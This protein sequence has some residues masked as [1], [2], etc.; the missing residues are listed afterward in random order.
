MFDENFEYKIN[1]ADPDDLAILD[2][3]SEAKF[4]CIKQLRIKNPPLHIDSR[5]EK[6]LKYSFCNYV[7]QF[8]IDWEDDDQSLESDY[9]DAL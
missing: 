5:L 8:E 3:T 1:M 6:L 7:K 2:Y 4:P 9:I